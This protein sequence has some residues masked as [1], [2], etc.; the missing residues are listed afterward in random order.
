M[1]DASADHLATLRRLSN[2]DGSGNDAA[3]DAAARMRSIYL[4]ACR[5][6]EVSPLANPRGRAFACGGSGGGGG[7]GGGVWSC[8]KPAD[9]ARGG[10]LNPS[11]ATASLPVQIRKSGSMQ[12]TALRALFERSARQQQHASGGHSRLAAARRGGIVLERGA[13]GA[14]AGAGG[15]SGGSSG[16]SRDVRRPP[17]SQPPPG[18]AWTFVRDPLTRLLSGYADIEGRLVEPH[19]VCLPFGSNW[20]RGREP[21]HTMLPVAAIGNFS[22]L[23]PDPRNIWVGQAAIAARCRWELSPA[24]VR[25][26]LFF[27]REPFGSVA[28]VRLFYQQLLAGELWHFQ[29]VRRGSRTINHAFP[30]CHFLCAEGAKL[31]ALRPYTP[32]PTRSPPTPAPPYPP[33]P[34][35]LEGISKAAQR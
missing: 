35:R 18:N 21:T 23:D 8:L 9:V 3:H 13:M 24:R 10:S 32:P 28:R 16:D 29:Y 2:V 5:S 26:G 20:S 19:G 15:S 17:L 1:A 30:Q 34:Q 7:G 33:R 11:A 12:I 27:R 22:A 14:G 6:A 31:Y 4:A 25:E